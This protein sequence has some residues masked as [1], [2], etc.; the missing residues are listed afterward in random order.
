MGVTGSF[1]LGRR[2]GAHVLQNSGVQEVSENKATRG[3][4]PV[5]GGEVEVQRKA[6]GHGS[7]EVG[8]GLGSSERPGGSV[9]G[10]CSFFR[11]VECA[12][13]HPCLLPW[14]SY[15]RCVASP[16]PLSD[17]SVVSLA[18]RSGRGSHEWKKRGESLVHKINTATASKRTRECVRG[19]RKRSVSMN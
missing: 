13:P 9:V 1:V 7:R 16:R 5:T 12:Q 15:L 6:G 2:R 11:C 4:G 18:A 19:K 8:L 3:S 17:P 10:E 14:I